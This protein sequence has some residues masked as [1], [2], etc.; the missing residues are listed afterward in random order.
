[1]SVDLPG[2]GKVYANAKVKRAL[3]ELLTDLTLYH[4]VRFTQVAEAI[5]EQGRVVGRR[6]VFEYV[7]GA[8]TLPELKNR[9]PGRPAKKTA[10]KK[11]T[12]NNKAKQ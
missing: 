7:E 11:K 12:T 4:G 9:N 8:R 6:E 1:V 10:V 3:E 5:Y 2:G